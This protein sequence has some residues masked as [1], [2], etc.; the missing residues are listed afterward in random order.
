MLDYQM[1]IEPK[2]FVE[3]CQQRS[4]EFERQGLFDKEQNE[5]SMDGAIPVDENFPFI[6]KGLKFNLK[7]FIYLTGMKIYTRKIAK[8]LNFE[9]VGKEN[10]KKIKGK[11]AIITCNHISLFDSFAVRHAVGNDIMFVAAEFNNW[12][13]EMGEVARHTGYIPITNKIKCIRKFGEALDYYLNKK[14]KKVLIYPEQAMWR[15]YKQPRPMKDGAF[16]YATKCNVP[17]LP[18]FITLKETGKQNQGGEI[19]QYIIH[20]L[21]PI[22]PNKELDKRDNTEYMRKE[23]YNAYVKCYEEF[24]GKKVEYTTEN[25]SSIKI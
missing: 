19:Y 22:L 7:K 1:L 2:E 15:N 20:I 16:H 6:R 11:G 9:V 21:D 14:N 4:I 13:G 23:T 8:Y 10:L 12:K 5:N 25:K 18:V 17:V 24:Y 3:E